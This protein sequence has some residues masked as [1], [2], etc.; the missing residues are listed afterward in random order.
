[1]SF[2]FSN[3]FSDFF[4]PVENDSHSHIQNI[5]LRKMP[6]VRTPDT[7]NIQGAAWMDE[8]GYL[9]HIFSLFFPLCGKLSIFICY[10]LQSARLKA[11]KKL[12]SRWKAVYLKIAFVLWKC[13]CLLMQGFYPTAPKLTRF[14]ERP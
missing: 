4:S 8:R 14:A 6:D 11:K 12:P 5:S 10:N 1:M 2:V 3:F 7:T 13:C 9:P